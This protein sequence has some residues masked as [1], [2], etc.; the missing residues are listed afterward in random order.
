MRI[1][2]NREIE[3]CA[4]VDAFEMR[5]RDAPQVGRLNGLSTHCLDLIDRALHVDR[6]PRHHGIGE[7][8]QCRGHRRERVV[9]PGQ[10]QRNLADV[11][12]AM[13]RFR[14]AAEAELMA[15]EYASPYAHSASEL[16]GL[17]TSCG[18]T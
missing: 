16:R 11:D 7:Q 17:L 12:R 10:F 2:C 15:V 8:R 4:Q 13:E 5:R 3:R 14:T 6:V 1:A 9:V 18:L